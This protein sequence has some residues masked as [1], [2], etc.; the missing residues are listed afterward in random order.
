MSVDNKK[1]ES[2]SMAG[3]STRKGEVYFIRERD[4]VS[5]EISPNVKIGL[6]RDDRLSTERNGEHNTG[7][8]R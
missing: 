7:N 3:V 6:T 1:K 8:P 4:V 5:G 2:V